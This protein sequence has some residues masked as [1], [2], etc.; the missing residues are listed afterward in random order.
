MYAIITATL[1]LVVCTKVDTLI[2]QTLEYTPLLLSEEYLAECLF[3]SKARSD[4]SY[5]PLARLRRFGYLGD[6]HPGDGC[7]SHWFFHFSRL[8]QIAS[9]SLRSI[10]HDPRYADSQTSNLKR[11]TLH[12]LRPSSTTELVKTLKACPML[13]CLDVTWEVKRIFSND[14]P[15]AVMGHALT[16]LGSKLRKLRLATSGYHWHS[17]EQSGLNN[18]SSLSNLRYLSLPVEAVLYE[19]AG[20][21]EVPLTEDEKDVPEY[22]QR[23]DCSDL[24]DSDES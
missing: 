5:T 16:K 7:N 1:A 21:Y 18:L 19:P 23:S 13:E 11:L 8:P 14:I 20:Q 12:G 6:V 24:S 17:D 22:Y 2:L 3:L 10:S 4:G 9:I 15:W